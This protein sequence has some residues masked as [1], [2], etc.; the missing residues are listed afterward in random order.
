M[1]ADMSGVPSWAVN[2]A[3]VVYLGALNPG[4]HHKRLVAGGVYVV[5]GV[6]QNPE[7]GTFG[8]YLEGVQNMLHPRLKIELG[9]SVKRFRPVRTLETDISEHF[10][11]LLTIDQREDA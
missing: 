4:L 3:S 11:H 7:T 10:S 6:M 1:G 8:L 5:R 9:Y 2:G